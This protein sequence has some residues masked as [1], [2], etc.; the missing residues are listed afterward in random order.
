MA[1]ATDNDGLTAKQRTAAV[2]LINQPTIEEAATATGVSARTL[3]RWMKQSNFRA[4]VRQF[5]RDV[6]QRAM[7]RL[8]KIAETRAATLASIIDDPNASPASRVS[9][10]R[11][12]A[13]LGGRWLEQQDILGRLDELEERLD[14]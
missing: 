8:Q 5:Q 10:Y 3:Y 2:E 4:A 11:T 7:A 13:E 6:Y 1:A 12:A 14:D 9:A